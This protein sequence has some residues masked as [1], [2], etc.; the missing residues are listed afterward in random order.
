MTPEF[1]SEAVRIV[2]DTYGTDQVQVGVEGTRTLVRIGAIALYETSKP[3]STPMLLVLDATQAKPVAHVQCGQLLANGRVP[4]ST[5]AISVGGEPWMQFSF[6]VPWE[7]RHGIVRFIA[8][9]RQRFVQD[10]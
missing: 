2:T 7:E 5:S 6:N 4:K 8:A 3:P 1:I 10:E 9:A